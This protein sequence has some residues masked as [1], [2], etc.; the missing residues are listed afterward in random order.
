MA[1]VS[2]K[3]IIDLNPA[4]PERIA[5]GEAFDI[6]L[7]NPPYV[8]AL[9]EKGLADAAS[10]RPFG[11]VP[12]AVARRSGADVTVTPD[13]AGIAR[14]FRDAESVAYTGAG[15]S[16]RI[17]LEVMEKLGLTDAVAFKSKAISDGVPAEVAAASQVELAVAPLTT[18]LA[19]PGVV[20]VAVFPEE[21]GTHI[22]MSVFLNTQ[23]ATEAE[24]VLEFLT[25]GEVDGELADAGIM[26]FSFT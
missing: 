8:R 14:L 4:I 22:D 18:V 13:V 16:G 2:V 12:L 7:T 10:H 19:T 9:I 25:A 3:Q 24:R 17:Y 21:L 6:A 11:R 23:S 5:T 1:G 20:P 15:T 26:R